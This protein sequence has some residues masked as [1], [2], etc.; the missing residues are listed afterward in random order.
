MCAYRCQAPT[1]ISPDPVTFTITEYVAMDSPGPQEHG[2]GGVHPKVAFAIFLYIFQSLAPQIWPPR[3]P[4]ATPGPA[5]AP[6]RPWDSPAASAPNPPLQM[7]LQ[8]LSTLVRPHLLR[9]R[10]TTAFVATK[11]QRPLLIY[12]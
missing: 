4:H 2:E 11:R 1:Y 3:P 5:T 7:H 9:T 8:S 12:P 6:H 10:W